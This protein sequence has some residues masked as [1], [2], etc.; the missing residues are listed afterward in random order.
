MFREECMNSKV[1][2][3][4]VKCLV[5]LLC[6]CCVYVHTKSHSQKTSKYDMEL[7]SQLSF[8]FQMFFQLISAHFLASPV[9]LLNKSTTA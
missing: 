3:N 1:V 4:L 9:H 6:V 5:F 7:W 8:Q 2:S